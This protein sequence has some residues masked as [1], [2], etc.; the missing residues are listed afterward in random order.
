[1]NTL[2]EYQTAGVDHMVS[3]PFGLP[4]A[5]LADAPGTGKT[6]MT[7]EAFKRTNCRNGI[8][9]VPSIIKEQW[10]R[11]MVEWDLCGEDEIQTVYGLDA[12]IDK[13]PWVIVNYDIIRDSKKTD[14]N[15]H[16]TRVSSRNRK[17]LYELNWHALVMD[18][19]HRLKGHDAEQTKA[20]LHHDY[21][22]AGKCYWKWALSGSIVPNRSAELY[23]LLRALAPGVIKPYDTWMKYR[24]RYCG[25]AWEQGKGASNIEELTARLQPFMLRRELKDVWLE[26][27]ELHENVFWLDVPYQEHPEWIGSDFMYEGTERRIVAEAKI[28]YVVAYLKDRLDSGVAKIVCFTYHRAVIEKASAALAKYKPLKIYGGITPAK[29]D[30]YLHQ[31]QTD[32]QSRVFFLQIASGGEGVDGLQHVASECVL[33]EPEWSPG[34]EDQA[35][36]RLR[37]Y[38]QEHAV[39][40]T[41]LYAKNSY[42]EVIYH[43]NQRKRSVIEVILKPNGG[44]FVMS[45]DSTLANILAEQKVTNELLA[46]LAGVSPVTQPVAPQANF[47]PPLPNVPAVIAT[48]PPAP[49]ATPAVATPPA[50]IAPVVPSAPAS[51]PVATIAAPPTIASPPVATPVVPV[52]TPPVVADKGTEDFQNKVIEILEKFNP[53]D[54]VCIDEM[55]RICKVFQDSLGVPVERPTMLPAEHRELFLQ[56]C[57]ASVAGAAQTAAAA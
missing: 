45:I 50:P 29:R 20:V 42:E 11:R 36:D 4:H 48:A 17:Q 3:M 12:T 46:K 28:P 13:R 23:P 26:C 37:R 1:M 49:A 53:V 39:I 35:V 57:T 55:K 32:P 18:E 6:I 21:G 33:A 25:G 34:R 31:F 19:A 41:K 52:A 47:A 15:G 9:L 56:H 8:I 44:T 7:I 38:G 43:A 30:A 2:R 5:L 40:L 54:T 22:L 10:K 16:E 14:D 24:D 51:A 27:P